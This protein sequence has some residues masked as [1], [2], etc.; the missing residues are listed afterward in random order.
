MQLNPL[1][2]VKALIL[3]NSGRLYILMQLFFCCKKLSKRTLTA[4]VRSIHQKRYLRGNSNFSS[5]CGQTALL[6]ANLLARPFCHFWEERFCLTLIFYVAVVSFPCLQ[7]N[8][9]PHQHTFI[10]TS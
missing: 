1:R 8:I 9:L 10:Y 5:Y 6:A 2:R 4:I 3:L 7:Q